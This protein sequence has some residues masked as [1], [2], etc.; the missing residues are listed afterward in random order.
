MRR[1]VEALL[2]THSESNLNIA[3]HLLDSHADYRR[4]IDPNPLAHGIWL[5]G[6]AHPSPMI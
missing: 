4:M 1:F 6:L 3:G 2:I 5:H